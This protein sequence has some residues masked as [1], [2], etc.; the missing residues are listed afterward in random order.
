M[1]EIDAHAST[2]VCSLLVGNK[3]DLKD[4]RAVKSD[5]G[6]AEF[7]SWGRPRRITATSRPCSSRWR[8][9]EEEGGLLAPSDRGGAPNV[10]I[11]R[12]K[13]VGEKSAS[14]C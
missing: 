6:A 4:K 14:C 12:G 11:A 2:D 13:K 9:D 5:E 1:G 7:R 8:R 3:A 10:S